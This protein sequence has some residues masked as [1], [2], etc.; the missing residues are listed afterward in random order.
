MEVWTLVL[1]TILM[2]IVVFVVL[3]L[4]GKREI[5]KLSVFD[6]VISIMIA[7]IAVFVIE[8]GKKPLWQGL[9]PII[10][11]III[12]ISVAYIALKSQWI[13][14][15]FDGKPSV[16][17]KNG[18][19]DRPEMARQRYNLDDLMQQLREQGVDN[20][21]DVRYAILEANGKLTVFLKQD[22][23]TPTAEQSQSGAQQ[24]GG[25]LEDD[26]TGDTKGPGP[27]TA[28]SSASSSGGRKKAKK[29]RPALR[30]P[31][32]Y[33]FTTLPLPL[34][35]DGKVQDHNLSTINKTRFWLKNQ[36]TL[37]GVSEF[38]D[39][40]FCSIDHRGHLFVDRK[41]K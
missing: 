38:K 3:R 28:G 10:V 26:Y 14:H 27:V 22:S 23:D 15:L 8:D 11:L 19:L 25:I 5:G 34:I 30:K 2:Y 33:H 29:Q 9:V 7:E 35:M 36:L 37:K 21:G 32:R 17:I 31:E 12:Q 20:I 13:R 41:H 16:I 4:M 24:S 6:V 1:R 39:V 18:Q 40:F